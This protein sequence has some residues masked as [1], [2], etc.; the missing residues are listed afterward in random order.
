MNKAITFQHLPLTFLTEITW[1]FY[2]QGRFL[3]TSFNFDYPH[4]M[5]E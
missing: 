2:W 1:L 3:K 4:R 5:D